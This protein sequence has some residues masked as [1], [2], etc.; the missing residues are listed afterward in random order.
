MRADA[1]L[2]PWWCW[3]FCTTLG[4]GDRWWVI[5]TAGCG[6][7]NCFQLQPQARPTVELGDSPVSRSKSETSQIW[8]F[9]CTHGSFVMW[10]CSLIF[11]LWVEETIGTL[12]LFHV[13]QE[14]ANLVL[15][16]IKI[17]S[18]FPCSLD[19]AKPRKRLL[20]SGFSHSLSLLTCLLSV[21]KACWNVV[22]GGFF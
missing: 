4:L 6:E 8:G 16:K 18:V 11:F 19:T 14:T 12:L 1:G 22:F 17:R 2:L 21:S 7:G 10:T 20:V 13:Y 9:G 3:V 5:L 15:I